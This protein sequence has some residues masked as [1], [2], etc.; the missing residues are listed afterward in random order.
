MSASGMPRCACHLRA[1]ARNAVMMGECEESTLGRC[2]QTASEA[3]HYYVQD[4][5]SVGAL[6]L[7]LI[8]RRRMN[9][10]GQ[11]VEHLDKV[12]QITRSWVIIG[13]CA[14]RRRRVLMWGPPS[15]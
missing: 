3:L 6:L 15:R 1:V 13:R 10:H 14:C 9:Q 2:K 7:L 8:V 12:F 11:A 5:E 4:E